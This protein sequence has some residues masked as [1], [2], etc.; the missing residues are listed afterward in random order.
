MN[1]I[2]NKYHRVLCACITSVQSDLVPPLCRYLLDNPE[3]CHG[4]TVL[5]L[6]SG[7]GAS[8]IAAKLCGAAHVV[9]NDI[10]P[11]MYLFLSFFSLTTIIFF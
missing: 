6:G 8:A 11:G 4:K 9:A 5:D 2:K 3:V 7:C 10:D 1:V